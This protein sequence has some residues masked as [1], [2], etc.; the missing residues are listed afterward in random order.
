M[1]RTVDIS[2]GFAVQV[3]RQPSAP[4]LAW[5]G[6]TVTYGRLG[7]LVDLA[8]ARLDRLSPGLDAPL[9][10]SLT[11]SPAA[12]AL[13]L[14]CLRQRRPV[15]IV[16]ADIPASERTTLWA[17]G[18]CRWALPDGDPEAPEA[19]EP[20]GAPAAGAP[21]RT[22]LMLTTSGTTGVPKIVPLDQA[23]IARFAAWASDRF[24][25]GAGTTVLSHAPLHFDLSLLDVWATLASGGQVVLV[26]PGRELRTDHL[27]E[28]LGR[29][30]VAVVQAVPM[31]Y[32]LLLDEA[33]RR[34]RRLDHLRH[35]IFTGDHLAAADVAGL[36]RLAPRARLYN[37]YGCTETN[38]SFIHEVRAYEGAPGDGRGVLP[39]GRPL[40]GVS[41][42]IIDDGGTELDGPGDGELYVSTPFQAQGYVGGGHARGAFVTLPRRPGRTYF[43]SGDIVVRDG[44]G[45]I[46]LDGR[47]DH[48]VKVRGVR[49]ST[50]RVEQVL[51]A[52][53]GIVDAAVMA[54][55]DPLAG[56]VLHAVARRSAGS[57]VGSLDLRSHC[58]RL[59]PGA[60]V[61]AAIRLQQQPLPATSTGKPDRRSLAYSLTRPTAHD[62]PGAT[63]MQ[64]NIAAITS[65]VIEEFLPD[66]AP[67]D[68]DPDHDLVGGGV[69]DSLGFLK[70]I[71]WLEA[72]FDLP[73]E[74]LDLA[75]E[76][77]A[78][79][80]AIAE[81]IDLA[82]AR[83]DAHRA[84]D[85][86]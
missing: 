17:R 29:H 76:S 20:D 42:A 48:Q 50:V 80:T 2:A 9:G 49:V 27:F 83:P 73:T 19:V 5:K 21:P 55:P 78:S 6:D 58:A 18:G 1:P 45:R 82:T 41:A 7:R 59:L 54:L 10:V 51:R 72:T 84:L 57:T 37:V 22:A 66:I 64:D 32:R 52:H 85:A 81:L 39:I 13:L 74:D 23:A 53:P 34:P 38:D 12:V 26:E 61:P 14:A 31:V 60:A 47:R 36:R 8:Q 40:P 24:G 4:A 65:F 46:F 33:E 68:L 28:L 79:I 77:F 71:A 44:R 56:H 63:S 25:L 35:V 69:I 30:R 15:L 43:R 75:P 16:P 67:D 70:V 3:D 62:D 11:R 86:S